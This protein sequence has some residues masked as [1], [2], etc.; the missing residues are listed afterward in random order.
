MG[1]GQQLF[2]PGVNKFMEQGGLCEAAPFMR[3]RSS[4]TLRTAE[5]LQQSGIVDVPPGPLEEAARCFRRGNGDKPNY[6]IPI[7]S[8]EL[9]RQTSYFFR[10]RKLGCGRAQLRQ[11]TSSRVELD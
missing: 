11:K 2:G 6:S 3:R 10:F 4:S 8:W 5:A 7:P 1:Q 9:L